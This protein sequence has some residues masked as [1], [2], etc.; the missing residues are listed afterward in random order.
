MAMAIHAGSQAETPV[1]NA[2]RVF[3]PLFACIFFLLYITDTFSVISRV[4]NIVRAE[5]T[6][7][8][9]ASGITEFCKELQNL[10]QQQYWQVLLFV[11][12]LYL[13]LQTFCVPGT[14]VLNAAVGAIMGTLLGVPYCTFLGTIGA[15]G[16]YFLSRIVGTSLV[17]VV[18]AR[19]MKGKGFTRIRNKVSH[20]RADLFVYLIF[21]RLT[22]ILPNWL[23]NLASPL[24]GVP[25]QTFA[26]A[27]ALGIVPQTYLTVRFG[28]LAHSGKPG[29]KKRI[30]TPWDTLLLA[31]IG[32]GILV[33]FRLKK[34]F[35]QDRKDGGNGGAGMEK[36]SVI[37]TSRSTVLGPLLV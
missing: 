35:A 14:V 24:L 9:S 12:S 30:V 23:V 18:D 32:V 5:E 37:T 15:M 17:E 29:E 22:P 4:Q 21:L 36:I 3:V 2:L 8:R 27:T 6:S 33:G 34:K 10:A 13:T 20:H 31:V 7:L 25:L 26:G 19:L 16:C 28:S 11:T 1:R